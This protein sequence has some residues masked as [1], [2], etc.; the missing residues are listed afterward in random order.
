MRVTRALR[1]FEGRGLF[2]HNSHGYGSVGTLESYEKEVLS[3]LEALWLY[4]ANFCANLVVELW[5]AIQQLQCGVSSSR[6]SPWKIQFFINQIKSLPACIQVHLKHV[7]QSENT[8]ADS[9]LNKGWTD[10]FLCCFLCHVVFGPWYN[11]FIT[12]APFVYSYTHE[13][14]LS[15]Q[16]QN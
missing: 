12:Y 6:A 7:G 14:S 8:H 4:V 16:L 1:E 13:K 10:I 2:L 11:A 5:Q 9:W 15:Q 3:I